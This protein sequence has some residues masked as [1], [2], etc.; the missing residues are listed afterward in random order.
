MANIKKFF[1]AAS[2]SLAL[3][4]AYNCESKNQNGNAEQAQSKFKYAE[5]ESPIAKD[6]STSFRDVRL[7][8]LSNGEICFKFNDPKNH[9][10]KKDEGFSVKLYASKYQKKK[11]W[12]WDSEESIVD[13][14]FFLYD[15][16]LDVYHVIEEDVM[17]LINNNDSFSIEV[18]TTFVWIGDEKVR[19][20]KFKATIKCDSIKVKETRESILEK[21]KNEYL[22]II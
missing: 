18:P 7:M 17:W 5:Y 22:N 19:S 20:P 2:A 8:V 10:P 14:L 15:K 16:N 21:K 1:I 3:F 9:L 13:E 12:S 6:D 4:F 11:K